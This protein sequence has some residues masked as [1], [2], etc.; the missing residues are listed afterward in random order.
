MITHASDLMQLPWSEKRAC[1]KTIEKASPKFRSLR[2][3]AI[4]LR[5]LVSG[6]GGF[7]FYS[8]RD[9]LGLM[10]IVGFAVTNLLFDWWLE[11]VFIL[12]FAILHL[13]KNAEQAVA[14]NDR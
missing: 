9:Q 10:S 2:W 11:R 7:L 1:F 13:E 12:P 3:H 14:P 8:L 6:L 5:L 4:F